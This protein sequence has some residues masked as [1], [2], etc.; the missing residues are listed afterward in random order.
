MP[1]DNT[2]DDSNIDS[3]DEFFAHTLDDYLLCL[4]ESIQEAQQ[5]L[6]AMHISGPAGQSPIAY[7]LPRVDFELR[8]TFEM[9]DSP[10]PSTGASTGAQVNASVI[11]SKLASTRARLFIRPVSPQDVSTQKV[12]AE[13][14]STIKGSFVAVPVSG[15]QPPPV[16][17][18]S[19]SKAPNGGVRVTATVR[20]ALGEPLPGVEVQFNLDPELSTEL[21]GAKAPVRFLPG[22]NIQYG[23]RVTNEEGQAVNTLNLAPKEQLLALVIDALGQ[24]ETVVAGGGQ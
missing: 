24:T 18:T 1:T 12:Q 22:T 23:V 5:Q 16:L 19:L 20:N 21:R 2:S 14:V 4:A 8:M 17:R 3:A 10:A 7:Q 9:A 13:A 6:S 11:G 15:G